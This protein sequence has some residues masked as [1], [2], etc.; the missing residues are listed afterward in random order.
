MSH[1]PFSNSRLMASSPSSERRVEHLADAG[2]GVAAGEPGGDPGVRQRADTIGHGNDQVVASGDERVRVLAL[3]ALQPRG[4]AAEA[5]RPHHQGTSA[6]ALDLSRME[7]EVSGRRGA[8]LEGWLGVGRRLRLADR[9]REARRALTSGR[10][11]GGRCR[12]GWRRRFNRRLKGG[13]SARRLA[14]RATARATAT[15]TT[16]RKSQTEIPESPE[17]PGNAGMVVVVVG[18]VVA[19]VVVLSVVAEFGDPPAEHAAT[20]KP[21]APTRPRRLTD[22]LIPRQP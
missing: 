12:R 13:S 15:A 14:T 9:R 11:S 18:V 5:G 10:R 20:T 6:L 3:L 16:A 7:Q 2:A 21:K 19:A 17:P 4:R 1:A 8:A 22:L